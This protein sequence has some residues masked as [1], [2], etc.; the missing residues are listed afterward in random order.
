MA[1]SP[2]VSDVPILV[3]IY[4]APDHE[5]FAFTLRDLVLKIL[6]QGGG[7]EELSRQAHEHRNRESLSHFSLQRT[8]LD[9]HELYVHDGENFHRL[10][11]FD[12]SG[13]ITLR[14]QL[15]DFAAMKL[16]DDVFAFTEVEMAG[17]SAVWVLTPKDDRS[18]TISWRLL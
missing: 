5:S 4:A 12:V 9:E 18:A 17:K 13:P 8:N 7:G 1:P 11:A 2:K 16:G 6:N 3:N 15:I 14:G 10:A